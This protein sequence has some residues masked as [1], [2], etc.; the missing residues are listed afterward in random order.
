MPTEHWIF[1]KCLFESMEHCIF[2]K[3]LLK[4]I[5]HAAYFIKVYKY[6]EHT[7]YFIRSLYKSIEHC[8]FNYDERVQQQPLDT[9]S[10]LPP[11]TTN[12][13]LTAP[14]DDQRT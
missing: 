6:I 1:S 4:Y 12:E 11:V 2:N 14:P 9:R 10:A 3:C 13:S 8:I 5:K 7:V